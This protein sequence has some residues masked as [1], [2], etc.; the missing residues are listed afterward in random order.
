MNVGRLVGAASYSLAP[1][2]TL[3]RATP[4]EVS[5]I[6]E[7]I[8]KYAPLPHNMHPS[9]W[10]QQL[11]RQIGPVVFLPASEWRYFVIAFKGTNQTVA[12]LECTFDLSRLE[13][14]VGFIALRS[15]ASGGLSR[16]HGVLQRPGRLFHVLENVYFDNSFFVDVTA[17]DVKEIRTIY[18]QLQKHDRSLVNVEK[19]TQQLGDLKALPHHSPLRFVGYFALLESVITHNPQPQD[20]YDSITRQVKKKLAL[21]NRRF[22]HPIDYTLFGTAT[23]DK[24][25]S[26]MYDYRSCVAHGGV[27]DFA[28]GLKLLGNHETALGLIKETVK[29]VTRLA[30]SEP[31]LLLDLRE[32]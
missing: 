24:V 16:R 23:P 31:Q 7:N 25:W 28:K 10:E 21:L 18:S 14:E 27:P 20:P 22:A 2:H 26:A 8:A 29:A 30:L 5:F 3:R 11:P 9:L 19:L 12:E 4:S 1:G 17:D 13:L 32:C 6:K 15:A